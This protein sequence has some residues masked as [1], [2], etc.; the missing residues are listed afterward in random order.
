MEG[1]AVV[2]KYNGKEDDVD[3]EVQHISHQLQIE[4]VHPL[5]KYV[6][7]YASLSILAH[8]KLDRIQ[9]PYLPKSMV[10]IHHV[11]CLALGVQNRKSESVFCLY[12]DEPI[13]E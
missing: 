3:H 10:K 2:H 11:P 8:F 6:T 9:R 7:G 12:R 1:Q 5:Q 13:A 4:D